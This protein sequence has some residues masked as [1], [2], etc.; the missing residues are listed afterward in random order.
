MAQGNPVG[1]EAAIIASFEHYLEQEGTKAGRAEF[2]R[3]LDDHLQ[4]RG[5]CSDLR[6]LLRTDITFDPQTAGPVS[7]ANRGWARRLRSR[8]PRA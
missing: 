4:D 7:D 1:L 5:F 6:R 3:I 2:I 8:W